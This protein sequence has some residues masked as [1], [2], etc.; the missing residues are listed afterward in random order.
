MD[1][2]PYCE[3]VCLIKGIQ[4]DWEISYNTLHPF[5]QKGTWL[6]YEDFT[7]LNL[8]SSFSDIRTA[9][10]YNSV[11]VS[12]VQPVIF[13]LSS[14]D[15]IH[16]F[17]IPVLGIK[18]DCMPGKAAEVRTLISG[19]GIFHGH[20]AEICGSGHSLIPIEIVSV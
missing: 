1:E 9:E 7:L 18:L 10:T 19:F 5:T 17:S 2:V 3:Q 6:E 20:C 8:L 13:Q 4:W 16:S 12:A 15:V 14:E 11:Y